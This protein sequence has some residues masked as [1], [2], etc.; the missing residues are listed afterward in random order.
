MLLVLV[1]LPL[2]DLSGDG[3]K[4]SIRSWQLD[5]AAEQAAL[6]NNERVLD[7]LLLQKCMRLFV[8]CVFHGQ[9]FKSRKH[10]GM[11]NQ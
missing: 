9:L 10:H 5:D 11:L 2:T 4:V 8:C 1:L 3:M 7:N 6:I